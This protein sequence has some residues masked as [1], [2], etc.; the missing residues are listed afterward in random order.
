MSSGTIGTGSVSRLLQEGVN[1]TFGDELK[2]HEKKYDKMFMSYDSRKAFEVD[3]Q[4]EGFNRASSKTE[5]DDITFDSKRQGFTP[6]YVHTTFAKGFIVTEEALEDELYGQL[7][8]GA[9]ALAR[10]MSITEEMEG[11]AIY[12][13]GF[14]AGNTM[15]D[16]DGSVLFSTTHSNGPSGGTYSNRLTTDAD[17]SE[18]SLEDMLAQVMTMTDARGLPA[19][20]QAQRLIVAAGTN[21][22]NA[23]R[24]L[25]SVLQN[26]TANN[27]TNAIKDMNS[28]RDG[29]MSNPYLTDADAWFLTT[30]APQGL[31][32]FTRRAVR[33]GQD[34][35][36][37]SGN[38]RFKADMRFVFG[39]TDARGAF[40]TPGA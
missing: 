3:V 17:L 40:G 24:I 23:Q 28:V 26:D 14:T 21:A 36:F 27:A 6:K 33:F 13:N 16:G 37:T 2:Q 10:V 19:A 34:D 15:T 30:D 32:H 35:S 9:S 22:F 18:A 7:S 31:K 4:M 11:A 12:N 8:D 25:G 20:L 38:A 29:W 1:D 39:W 5:G